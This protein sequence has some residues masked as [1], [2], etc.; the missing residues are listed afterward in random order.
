MKIHI[1][2]EDSSEVPEL[3]AYDYQLILRWGQK[4]FMEHT[5]CEEDAC[6][7]ASDD[8]AKTFEKVCLILNHLDRGWLG[9]VQDS[10]E[11]QR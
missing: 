4:E 1:R 9:R 7:K 5:F 6:L 8:N 2:Y 10:W 11:N 3:N